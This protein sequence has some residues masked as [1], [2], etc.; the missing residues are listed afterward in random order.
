VRR[1]RSISFVLSITLLAAA[2]AATAVAQDP[3]P[4]ASRLYWNEDRWGRFSTQELAVGSF[5]AIG[6]IALQLFLIPELSG[7]S[8]GVLIDDGVRDL[9]HL[10]DR[11]SRGFAARV[12]DILV[13]ANLIW[14]YLVDTLIIAWGIDDSRDAAGQMFWINAL[15]YVLTTAS[16]TATKNIIARERP[17]H[18]E[19]LEDIEYDGGCLAPDRYRSFFSGHAAYAFTG[20]SLMCI[21]HANLPL[22]DSAIA[23]AAACI[24]SLTI[25]AT[26]ATLRIVA[27][28]H[29]FTDVLVGAVVG[30]LSGLVIPAAFHYGWDW[31]RSHGTN[32][33]RE[34]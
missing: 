9:L 5:A 15:S 18:D 25:A 29:Y 27:D 22:Y 26:V 17:Y 12:S 33:M 13:N 28:K 24:T 2:P 10:R 16:L 20:A 32:P 30:V 4:D 1:L 21:H 8:G 31:S 14:P 19:C 7:A 11:P 3:E 23:D 34:P 6:G